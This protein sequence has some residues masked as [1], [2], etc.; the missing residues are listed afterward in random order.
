MPNRPL[1]NKQVYSRFCSTAE[2]VCPSSVSPPTGGGGSSLGGCYPPSRSP[3]R[4]EQTHICEPAPPALLPISQRSRL[5]ASI[6]ADAGGLLPHPF[7]PYLCRT[8]AAIG[9]TTLCC[10]LASPPRYH[11]GAPPYG[12]GGWPSQP[13]RPGRGVGKFLCPA[14][15]GQRR[16]PCLSPR[17]IPLRAS[18]SPGTR[19]LNSLLKRQVLCRLS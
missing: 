2:A 16:T 7:T 12:F 19:T 15:A 6:T 5:A 14:C 17:A 11:D 9:G 3:L 4:R 8:C 10:R 18:G 1:H 13:R